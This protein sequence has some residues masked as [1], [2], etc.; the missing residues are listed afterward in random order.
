MSQSK[1]MAMRTIWNMKER[2]IKNF[3]NKLAEYEDG[4]NWCQENLP[5]LS[6]QNLKRGTREN[7]G[8]TEHRPGHSAY[9]VISAYSAFSLQ[10]LSF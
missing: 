2:I 5:A 6:Y 8:H 10:T 7:G 3:R 4:S 1:N 9:S